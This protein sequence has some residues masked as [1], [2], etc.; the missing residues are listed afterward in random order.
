MHDKVVI[1]APARRRRRRVG[2][3]LLLLA[4]AAPA[5]AQDVV[6]APT[7]TV[8]LALAVAVARA[9]DQSEEIRLARAEVDLADAQ[10]LAARA[11]ALP[12]L[13]GSFSYTRTFA[14]QF[15]DA[16][17]T[18]VPDM[19]DPD[20]TAPIEDRVAYL[21]ENVDLAAF[22]AL[23]DVFANLPFGR[24]NQ[25]VA[26]IVGSQ[27]LY[28]GGRV[29][30]ARR[31]ASE[32]RE[33]A[34]LGLTEQRAEIELQIRNA[35]YRALLAGELEAIAR[36][37]VVQAQSF[38]EQEQLRLRAG[39]ASELDLLRAEVSLENLRPQLVEAQNAAQLAL[40]DLKR[41]VDIPLAQPIRLTTPLVVPT[42]QE[43]AAADVAPELLVAQRAAVRAAERQ[44]AIREQQVRIARGAFLPSVDVSM[45]YGRL[46]FPTRPAD[47]T[48]RWTTDWTGTIGVRVPIFSGFRRAAELEQ[49]HVQLRQQR[50]QLSQLREN[51]QLQYEQARGERERAAATI[52]ARQR[53]VEQAQRVYDLTVLRY[54]RGLATQLEVT[55]ARL[56]LL[57][58][59]TNL[60]QAL[61]DFYTAD[62]SL[63]RALVGATGASIDSGLVPAPDAARPATPT[64]TPNPPRR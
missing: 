32:Y 61:S 24:P 36:A 7:D 28:S 8:P 5:G 20:P 64:P 54:D 57:Q 26:Q 44:V 59:R 11:Q 62:A 27:P 60:A 42:A 55:D 33:T 58:A 45:S 31:I 49:A 56:A 3:A 13:D 30:A 22:D 4:I 50:L 9:V 63:S 52:A 12:Q 46:L 10:V 39:T 43:L 17:S 15:D 6:P 16:G 37:A 51:V 41:L 34:R 47:L 35:Y 38:L 29:G 1:A 48:G 2:M 21:E 14:S 23:T 18:D 40:L 53:T 19:F 25:Y